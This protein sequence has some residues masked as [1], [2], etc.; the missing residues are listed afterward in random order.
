MASQADYMEK[1]HLRQN[2]R[3]IWHTDLTGTIAASPP[4][5]CFS[6]FC[7]PYASYLLRKRALYDDMSRY[8]CCGGY[9]PCSGKC[10]EKRCPEVCLCTEVFCCFANSVA[11]TR[12]MLQDEF[13]IQTTECDNCIIAFTL[14]L[15]QLACICSIIA[16][17]LGSEELREASDLLT[18]LSNLVY[19]SVCAC[20]QSSRHNTSLSW[21]KEMAS[22]DLNHHP[23]L[24]LSHSKCPVSFSLFR[25]LLV[26]ILLLRYMDNHLGTY[27]LLLFKATPRHGHHHQPLTWLKATSPLLHFK[28]IHNPV[29]LRIR[30]R[31]N[32]SDLFHI[33]S[34][35]C[36]LKFAYSE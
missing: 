24:R 13:N 33:V 14:C 20:M 2:Y 10:G 15:S 8:T 26:D 22:L 9:M 28:A 27:P 36:K 16:C 19:C 12:F 35:I 4:Y 3:N 7:A 31:A 6:L 17:L 11:S 34:Q 18:C 29:I 23:W 30:L 25:P 32:T 1:I 5:C 21:I